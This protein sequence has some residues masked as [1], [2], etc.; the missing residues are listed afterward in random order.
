MGYQRRVHGDS[1]RSTMSSTPGMWTGNYDRPGIWRGS[2]SYVRNPYHTSSVPHNAT[3]GYHP[4]RRYQAA[5]ATH[6]LVDTVRQDAIRQ[7]L[8]AGYGHSFL[9]PYANAQAYQYALPLHSGTRPTPNAGS[10]PDEVY[11]AAHHEKFAPET[12]CEKELRQLRQPVEIG[13]DRWSSL[14]SAGLGKV[15]PSTE[16]SISHL[17]W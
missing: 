8:S 3:A 13:S 9:A 16:T 14:S 2:A 4:D 11:V 10:V 1:L 12:A 17:S 7:D 15:P 5:A 6:R